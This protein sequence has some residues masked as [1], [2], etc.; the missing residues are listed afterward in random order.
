MS[1]CAY[2]GGEVVITVQLQLF[3][4]LSHSHISGLTTVRE[5]QFCVFFLYLNLTSP[6]HVSE[7]VN[8]EPEGFDISKSSCRNVAILISLCWEWTW[9]VY[10]KS[11]ITRLVVVYL[12]IHYTRSVP[13]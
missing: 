3:D 6:N 1:R 2:L 12:R 11:S 5:L 13:H 10:T 9:L 7:V 8:V 4:D